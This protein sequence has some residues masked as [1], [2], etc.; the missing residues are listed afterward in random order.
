MYL[1]IETRAQKVTVNPEHLQLS[2]LLITLAA[3]DHQKKMFVPP[4][5][6]KKKCL[7]LHMWLC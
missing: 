1:L 3:V 6:V 4:R 7:C 5:V 2:D